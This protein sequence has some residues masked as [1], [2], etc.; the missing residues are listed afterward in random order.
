[1]KDEKKKLVRSKSKT[2]TVV[3]KSGN[4]SILVEVVRR[5][6][7]PVYGKIV[8]K[9]RKFMVHDEN[10]TA[11]VGDIVSFI[12]SRPLSK[13]KRWEIVPAEKQENI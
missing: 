12:D 7:H 4:K 5:V 1:M 2:G 6:R 13:R 9:R 8:K 10:N 3:R 11:Q